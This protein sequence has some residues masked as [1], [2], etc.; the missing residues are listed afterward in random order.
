MFPSQIAE[1]MHEHA[2]TPYVVMLTSTACK[3]TNEDIPEFVPKYDH[4]VEEL[5]VD[6]IHTE[7][8]E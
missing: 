3:I 5:K 8:V 1:I 4:N 2:I 6:H 7:V